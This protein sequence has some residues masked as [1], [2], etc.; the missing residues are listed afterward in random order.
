[1]VRA[2]GGAEIA[3]LRRTVTVLVRSCDADMAI[4]AGAMA[5]ALRLEDDDVDVAAA[6]AARGLSAEAYPAGLVDAI[7]ERLGAPAR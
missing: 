7:A 5:R 2:W 1:V 4:L 3:R 6:L